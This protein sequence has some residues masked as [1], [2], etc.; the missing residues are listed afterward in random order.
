MSVQ[1]VTPILNVSDIGQS[2]AW[3]EQLGWNRGFSWNQG[4]MI[5][6]GPAARAANEHGPAGFGSVCSGEAQI[7]LCCGAQG[8]RGTR[9]PRFPG[10]DATDGVWMSWWMGSRADVDALHETAM[11]AGMTI[12]SPPAD[13]PWGVREFHLRHPDGHTFRVSAGTG[14]DD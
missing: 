8:S 2:F 1:S 13:R 10:D 5:G 4:G 3:F 9:P 12:A 7:F 14:D 11:H 6:E